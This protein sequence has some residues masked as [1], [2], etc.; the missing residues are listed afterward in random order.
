[1]KNRFFL[2]LA[3]VVAAFGFAPANAAITGP[4]SAIAPGGNAF[5]AALRVSSNGV[6]TATTASSSFDALNVSACTLY[7]KTTQ[8][9]STNATTIS[10]Q[11]SN[12][13]SDWFAIP[14]VSGNIVTA[15]TS[16]L[17]DVALF[18]PAPVAKMRVLVTAGNSNSVTINSL[19][20]ACK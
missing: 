3:I 10:F 9:G 5:S 4:T 6:I 13:N 1:M 12:N 15:S 11:G 19:H 8:G 14:L 16:S 7:Y 17:D 18:Y 20:V 2:A